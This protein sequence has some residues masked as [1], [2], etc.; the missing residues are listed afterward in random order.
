MST[1]GEFTTLASFNDAA[2][3]MP[4]AG[5]L[6]ASDG[7]FYGC[8][9]GAV[10][11]MTPAGVLSSLVSLIPLNGIHPGAGLVVGPDGNFY[12]CTHSRPGESARPAW[13]ETESPH[14]NRFKRNWKCAN[15]AN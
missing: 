5:L 11:K 10:F 13:A 6:L 2:N 14:A 15:S 1:N 7:N 4:E 3:K 8:S 12:G 9:Q